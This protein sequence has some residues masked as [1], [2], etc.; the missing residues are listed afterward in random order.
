M[1][2]PRQDTLLGVWAGEP[3]GGAGKSLISIHDVRVYNGRNTGSAEAIAAALGQQN[4][5]APPAGERDV[6]R[7]LDREVRV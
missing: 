6:S 3:I 2:C 1:S 5:L 4:G 7:Y